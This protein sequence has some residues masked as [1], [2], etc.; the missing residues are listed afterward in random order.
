MTQP[1]RA[2]QL[3]ALDGH[4]R[5]READ[6]QDFAASAAIAGTSQGTKGFSFAWVYGG[7]G[8]ETTKLEL[9]PFDLDGFVSDAL[10]AEET[11]PRCT[12]HNDGVILNLRGVNLNEGADPED[13]IS[14]RLWIQDTVIIGV[15]KRKLKAIDDLFDAMQRGKAPETPGDFA[16]KLS[17]RLSD[18]AEP[19][20]AALND[21][22][23]TLEEDLSEG[24][25]LQDARM[26]LA[27]LR[28][29]ATT[30]RRY[31]FPQR[32]ALTTLEIEDVSWLQE[33][34]RSRL[35]EAADRVTRMAEELEAIRDRAQ[36]VQ[37]QIMDR[38]AETMNSQMLLLSIVAA[39]FLPL[40]LLTGLLGVNV[41]GIPLADSAWGF[42]IVCAILIVV[43]IGQVWLFKRL[44][45]FGK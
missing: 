26:R 21:A 31:M 22:I 9:A 44:G 1:P 4:G 33:R 8:Q 13:M 39:I 45:M 19:I 36:I 38:R 37:D 32:D 34:D 25:K 27:Q 24:G 6:L 15:W 23:D 7:A 11:R 41:G 43:G 12:V 40:G 14:V 29:S 20:V 16:A 3:F 17:L 35:R 42:A 18:R 10:T 30:L 5:S 2:V 28:H